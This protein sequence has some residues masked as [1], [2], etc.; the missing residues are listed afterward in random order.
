MVKWNREFGYPDFRDSYSNRYYWDQ[1]RASFKRLIPAQHKAMK[2]PIAPA[3]LEAMAAE[4]DLR[5]WRLRLW[6]ECNSRV[7]SQR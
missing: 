2:L 6:L 4:A 7:R 5:W 1:F 3:H